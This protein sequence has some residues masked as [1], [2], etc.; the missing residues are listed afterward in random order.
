VGERTA[1]AVS[2]LP[3]EER[4]SEPA[5]ATNRASGTGWT[6]VL[7][8][9]AV[10]RAVALTTLVAAGSFKLQRFTFETLW[11]YDGGWYIGIARTG[12][13]PEPIDGVQT[14][15]P[16]FPLYPGLAK[17]L[18]V[19]GLPYDAALV[20][21]A[22]VGLLVALAGVHRLARRH[23][24]ERDAA[25]AVW[26]VALSPAS[27]V[28]SMA[29][30]SSLFLA[31]TVWAFVWW[32]E[33]RLPAAGVAAAVATL[34]RPNGAV[35]VVALVVAVLVAHRQAAADRPPAGSGA[36]PTPWRALA[37]T[38]GPAAVAFAGWCALQWRWAGNPLTFWRA[39]SAWDEVQL[40]EFVADPR[41]S[42]LPHVLFGLGALALVAAVARRLPVGWTVFAVLYL[43]PSLL[44]GVVGMGRYATECF[45]VAIA[46]AVVLRRS[47]ARARAGLLAL[48]AGGMV[49]WGVAIAR[50]AL[51]P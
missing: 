16:F 38:A 11:S 45:P 26:L 17:V 22:N 4:R 32:E 42:E 10:S 20:L 29:Y 23:L 49:I 31:A 8:A 12:Y 34:V 2:S 35:V 19:T 40:W 9:W 15:W 51:V 50:F 18:H 33:G 28:F 5:G 36:G 37:W 3:G 25:L 1:T 30:P 46:A 47:G 27:V 21:I 14:H 43:A 39:K 7:T 6:T 44:L 13:G 48:G 24:A 41:R